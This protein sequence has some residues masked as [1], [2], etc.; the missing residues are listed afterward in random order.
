MIHDTFFSFA[1]PFV[2]RVFIIVVVIVLFLCMHYTRYFFSCVS[3]KGLPIRLALSYI[4]MNKH[5]H[6]RLCNRMPPTTCSF[7]HGFY[8]LLHN[9]GFTYTKIFNLA[10]LHLGEHPQQ[11]EGWIEIQRVASRRRRVRGKGVNLSA[12]Q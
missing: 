4:F 9:D 10:C 6:M 11:I 12:Q 7:G 3:V 5:A 1:S 2:A 8:L